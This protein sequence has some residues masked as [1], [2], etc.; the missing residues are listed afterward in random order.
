VSVRR[1][2]AKDAIS[3]A[4]VKTARARVIDTAGAN[5]ERWNT[6]VFGMLNRKEAA[7]ERRDAEMAKATGLSA[8]DASFLCVLGEMIATSRLSTKQLFELGSSEKAIG[9]CTEVLAQ[10]LSETAGDGH[11]IRFPRSRWHGLRPLTEA[12]P[13]EEKDETFAGAEEAG[14]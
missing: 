6:L 11:I 7:G 3:P 1:A 12:P 5:A 8:A 4:A 2:P 9:I 10:G 13:V 14:A